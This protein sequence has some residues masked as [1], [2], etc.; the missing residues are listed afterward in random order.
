MKRY[1]FAFEGEIV[2]DAESEEDAR[3]IADDLLATSA[4]V[5]D[6]CVDHSIYEIDLTDEEDLEEDEDV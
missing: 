2:V 1:T 4:W 6:H 5:A 3:E